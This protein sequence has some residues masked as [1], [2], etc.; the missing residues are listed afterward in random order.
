[1][2]ITLHSPVNFDLGGRR[3]AAKRSNVP[4]LYP[5]NKRW[6]G[7]LEDRTRRGDS[8]YRDKGKRA[9]GIYAH[10]LGQGTVKIP[11]RTFDP[12]VEQVT[13][14]AVS[15]SQIRECP[16]LPLEVHLDHD[17]SISTLAQGRIPYAIFRR[18]R[19]VTVLALDG[20]FRSRKRPH[21]LQEVNESI[22]S[23]P[24]ITNCNPPTAV[25]RIRWVLGVEA[26]ILH[27]APPLPFGSNPGRAIIEAAVQAGAFVTSIAFTFREIPPKY[28]LHVTA[29]TAA[30]E[31][32]LIPAPL[33]FFEYSPLPELPSRF[34]VHYEHDK[35]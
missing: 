8:F 13:G 20:V 12:A 22:F 2:Q 30:K 11:S 16:H 26:A 27:S 14:Q 32:S 18:V 19:A 7:S 31:P 23:T 10:R 6:R 5:W 35:I 4:W 33:K 21:V 3:R 17:T 9:V 28:R 15:V 25:S 24:S 34:N 29:V 1:M